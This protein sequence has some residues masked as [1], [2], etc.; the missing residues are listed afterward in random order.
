[1]NKSI[2]FVLATRKTLCEFLNYSRLDSTAKTYARKFIMFE[3]SDYEIMSLVVTGDYPTEKYNPLKEEKV[4][5]QYKNIILEN[6]SEI[7]PYIDESTLK[8]VITEVSPIRSSSNRLLKS[9]LK[10]QKSE[11]KSER[12]KSLKTMAVAGVV[13]GFFSGAGK[14]AYEFARDKAKQG[15]APLMSYLRTP[16]GKKVGA[17][18]TASLIIY[19]S[20]VVYEK[21]FSEAGKTCGRLE[22]SEREQCIK[23]L[24]INA[25]QNQINSLK[26]GRSA[27]ANKD[28]Q[29]KCDQVIKTKIV[30]LQIKL[31]KLGK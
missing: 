18:V 10:E 31:Q 23:K 19:A 29:S 25:I 27:C 2:L 7:V 21:Y 6:L 3:A 20:I 9:F 12:D 11:K 16:N 5:N 28:N 13:G 4:F 22:G 8:N 14:G 30:K 24:K 15:L 26:Q 1:M 17:A